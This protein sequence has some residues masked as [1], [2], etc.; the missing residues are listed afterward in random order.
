MSFQCGEMP[1]LRHRRSAPSP[2]PALA[3][4]TSSKS[5]TS[6]ALPI[7]RSSRIQNSHNPF[8]QSPPHPSSTPVPPALAWRAK[9][10]TSSSPTSVTPHSPGIATRRALP[11]ASHR[12]PHIATP[13]AP[14]R[15]PSMSKLR[16]IA[17]RPVPR[18]RPALRA[19]LP[20]AFTTNPPCQ[21]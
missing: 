19:S 16:K 11:R 20:C 15:P 1:G 3:H 18:A 5:L 21:A 12:K 7:V 9:T 6:Q 17:A 2:P 10:S 8:H 13:P 4:P 14:K